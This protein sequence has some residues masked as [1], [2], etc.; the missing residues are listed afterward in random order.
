MFFEYLDSDGVLL[1]PS[2]FVNCVF[3]L[4]FTRKKCRPCIQLLHNLKYLNLNSYSN[5]VPLIVSMDKNI[6]E[7]D[8]CPKLNG[9]LLFPF[10]PKEYREKLFKDFQINRLP[11]LVLCDETS[12]FKIPNELYN[13]VKDIEEYINFAMS[14]FDIEDFEII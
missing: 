11:F 6:D 7:W 12:H 8:E 5:L 13:N 14:C 3:L 4:F 2:H 1:P 10:F 9:W